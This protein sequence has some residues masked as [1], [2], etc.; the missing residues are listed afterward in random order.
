[1]KPIIQ[2][3]IISIKL[4]PISSVRVPKPGIPLIILW[5]KYF[6]YKTKPIRTKIDPH[7]TNTSAISNIHR[8]L[9]NMP[10]VA[11]IITPTPIATTPAISRA[12]VVL[13]CSGSGRQSV[14]LLHTKRLNVFGPDLSHSGVAKAVMP[15]A[16]GMIPITKPIE[17]KT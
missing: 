10:R 1:M 16:I 9:V 17:I 6:A 12:L 5:N 15:K 8:L 4:Y 3:R 13:A 14:G 7:T 11:A 2:V